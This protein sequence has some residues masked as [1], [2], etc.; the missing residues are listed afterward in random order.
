MNREDTAT[1]MKTLVSSGDMNLP[2][3]MSNYQIWLSANM[4][5]AMMHTSI[6]FLNIRKSKC[7]MSDICLVLFPFTLTNQFILFGYFIYRSKL[8]MP[9]ELCLQNKRKSLLLKSL[10]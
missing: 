3:M 10:F 4:A 9:A 5:P 6:Y 2:R 8:T 1:Y 7:T